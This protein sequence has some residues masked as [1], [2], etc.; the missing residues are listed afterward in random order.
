MLAQHWLPANNRVWARMLVPE[1]VRTAFFMLPNECRTTQSEVQEPPRASSQ[2]NNRTAMH[3]VWHR[4]LDKK[5]LRTEQIFYCRTV[6]GYIWPVYVDVA[7]RTIYVTIQCWVGQAEEAN[8]RTSGG[9]WWSE[10]ERAQKIEV[11]N[12]GDEKAFRTNNNVSIG[13][14]WR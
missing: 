7:V 12:C 2:I 9:V 14:W 4:N 10:S 13:W 11:A 6:L 8:E 1:W 3:A 5:K